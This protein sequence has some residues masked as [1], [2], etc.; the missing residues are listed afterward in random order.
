MNKLAREI[1]QLLLDNE[2]IKEYLSL[3]N[4]IDNDQVLKETK[5]KLNRMRKE[6]CK[7]KDMDSSQY[8]SLL[9]VY[10]KD[11]RIIRYEQLKKEINEYFLEISDIL[12]LK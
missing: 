5:E 8:F 2:T 1:N 9:D 4:E 6:V 10:N 3:K 11:D 12:Y 7:N